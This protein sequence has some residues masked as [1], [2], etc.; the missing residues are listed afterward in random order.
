MDTTILGVELVE[1]IGYVASFIILVSMFM[2][3]LKRLRLINL[4]GSTL[5]AIYGFLI[6]SPPVMIM[7]FGIAAINIHYLRQIFISREYFTVLPVEKDGGYVSALLSFHRRDI[8]RFMAVEKDILQTS[9]FRYLVLRNMKPAGIFIA[10]EYDAETLEV[11]LDY[12]IPP[13]QDFKTGEH[14]YRREQ[15]RFKQAGYRTFV[16]FPRSHTHRKY[17]K[18]M[19]FR[20]TSIDNEAA[21]IKHI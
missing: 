7:N 14:I 1:W 20:E 9:D 19:G 15:E 18:R 4:F 17:L 2:G 13:F 10:R 12:A 5:F 6:A 16:A 8:E 3:S 11:M 21:L